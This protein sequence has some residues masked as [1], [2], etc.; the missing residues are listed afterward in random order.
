MEKNIVLD[1]SH[2]KRITNPRSEPSPLNNK[3]N[4]AAH[5]MSKD[6]KIILELK[7]KLK[8]MNRFAHCAMLFMKQQELDDQFIQEHGIFTQKGV[9]GEDG[10]TQLNLAMYVPY[11]YKWDDETKVSS[12]PVNFPTNNDASE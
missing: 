5:R 4:D 9:E 8:R 3:E 11:S 6:T 1:A 2:R 7:R 10:K 12:E